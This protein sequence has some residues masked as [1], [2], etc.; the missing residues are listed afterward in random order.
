MA[1]KI[2]KNRKKVPRFPR[3]DAHKK[4]RLRGKPWR[5]PKGRHGRVKRLHDYHGA[6]PKIG[7]STPKPYRHLLSSGL[8]VIEIANTKEVQG[9][10][11]KTQAIKIRNVGLKKK[12]MIIKEAIAKKIKISN[13]RKPEAFISKYEKK[14]KPEKK[15]FSISAEYL[16]FIL[17]K[18]F[19]KRLFSKKI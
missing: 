1:N 15:F 7:H 9:I 13:V 12:L 3:Q 5:K 16:L 4:I 11:P 17:Q 14:K 18:N 8:K 6:S 2:L 19:T 10:D